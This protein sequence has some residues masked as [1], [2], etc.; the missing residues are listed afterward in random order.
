MRSRAESDSVYFP[1][2]RFSCFVQAEARDGEIIYAGV[3]GSV[4]IGRPL[5]LGMLVAYALFSR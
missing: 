4:L 2:W 5:S 1:Y 3:S